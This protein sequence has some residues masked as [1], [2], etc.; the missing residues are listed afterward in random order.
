MSNNLINYIALSLTAVE[1]KKRRNVVLRRH[2]GKQ[3]YYN[4]CENL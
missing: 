3:N 1:P 4:F 2:C